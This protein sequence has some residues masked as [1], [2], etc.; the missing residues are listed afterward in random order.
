MIDRALFAKV[1]ALKNLGLSHLLANLDAAVATT[2]RRRRVVFIVFRVWS[3]LSAV[4]ECVEVEAGMVLDVVGFLF[5]LS[6]RYCGVARAIQTTRLL[7]WR[8]YQSCA[9]YVRSDIE[10]EASIVIDVN[11]RSIERKW[12]LLKTM[13]ALKAPATNDLSFS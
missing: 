5:G 10:V 13:R 3:V 7:Y 2:L 1:I 4:L 11:F 9:S 8:C 6:F 12:R